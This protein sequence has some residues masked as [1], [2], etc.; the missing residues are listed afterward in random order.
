MSRRTLTRGGPNLRG[1]ANSQ[2]HHIYAA[3][4]RR[5]GTR[6]SPR[7]LPVCVT[8]DFRLGHGIGYLVV[9]APSASPMDRLRAW[10]WIPLARDGCSRAIA[11]PSCRDRARR[12]SVH[13][14]PSRVRPTMALVRRGYYMQRNAVLDARCSAFPDRAANGRAGAANLVSDRQASHPMIVL[15]PIGDRKAIGPP[16]LRPAHVL[17]YHVNGY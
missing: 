8:C 4:N 6:R 14:A 1:R 13:V 5:C 11:H 12:S 9:F 17:P 7:R 2:L 16:G 3:G 10:A 15:E